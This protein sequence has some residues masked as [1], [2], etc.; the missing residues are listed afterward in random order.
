MD[1][2]GAVGA[3]QSKGIGGAA[4]RL[5]NT[6]KL[7]FKVFNRTE[8]CIYN[9]KKFGDIST[10]SSGDRI[11]AGQEAVLSS[12]GLHTASGVV[13]FRW[14][15]IVTC[16]RMLWCNVRIE[17]EMLA[18]AIAWSVTQDA[19][20]KNKCRLGVGF[21]QVIESY[22]EEVDM[23]LLKKIWREIIEK[24]CSQNKSGIVLRN[25]HIK[26][27]HILLEYWHW[28]TIR[29]WMTKI[30]TEANLR[31]HDFDKKGIKIWIGIEFIK[32]E[33]WREPR[34]KEDPQLVKLKKK[35]LK[36]RFTG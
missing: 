5:I 36:D 11:K 32:L 16:Y 33:W 15:C 10:L 28:V 9:M 35:M 24:K 29:G 34:K 7:E 25:H 3:V 6:K 20:G 18:V 1:D 12:Q 13:T 27:P 23:L 4:F 26:S 2:L 8:K 19:N 30:V 17:Q 14:T 31:F 21:L 22:T